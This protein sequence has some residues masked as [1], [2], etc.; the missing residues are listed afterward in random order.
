MFQ[1][2]M[3]KDATFRK[4]CKNA[5]T[6]NE[7]VECLRSHV[8]IFLKSE[9]ASGNEI[10]AVLCLKKAM[11]AKN[12]SEH[13]VEFMPEPKTETEPPPQEYSAGAPLYFAADLC[14]FPDLNYVMAQAPMTQEELADALVNILNLKSKPD[15]PKD[16]SKLDRKQYYQL[17][18]KTLAKNGVTPAFLEA[19]PETTVTRR[20]FNSMMFDLAQRGDRK[21]QAGCKKSQTE[22]EQADCLLDHN[23]IFSKDAGIYRDEI[24][25]VLCQ[26]KDFIKSK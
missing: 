26:K 11:I 9:K 6:E 7:R 21:F 2:A 1:I 23:Y 20:S 18:A 22:A 3:E 14:N 25:S 8:S 15:W 16:T 10:V 12:S 4:D 17:E 13:R 19:A 5:Q 24:L